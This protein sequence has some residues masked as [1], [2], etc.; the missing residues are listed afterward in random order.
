[1]DALLNKTRRFLAEEDGP[2]AAEYAVML[3]LIIIIA[4]GTITA[5]GTKVSSIYSNLETTLPTGTTGS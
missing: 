4:M 5:L 1:M 3:A 2:T